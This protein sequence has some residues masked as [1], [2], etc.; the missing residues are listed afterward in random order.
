MPLKEN[1]TL[2]KNG[3]KTKEVYFDINAGLKEFESKKGYEI[4]LS[5][6]DGEIYVYYSHEGMFIEAKTKSGTFIETSSK[7]RTLFAESVGMQWEATLVFDSPITLTYNSKGHVYCIP[8][9]EPPPEIIPI[10]KA[11]STTSL[12]DITNYINKTTESIKSCKSYIAYV[13]NNKGGSATDTET[14]ESLINKLKDIK[15]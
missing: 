9:I 8:E 2:T 11:P 13:I 10:D 3:M 14:L 15:F 6:Q 7:N 1:Y 4:N 12:N 5:K